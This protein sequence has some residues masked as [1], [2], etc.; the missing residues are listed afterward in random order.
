MRHIPLT[1]PR[2]ARRWRFARPNMKGPQD[3]H[4]SIAYLVLNNDPEAVSTGN[5]ERA[6]RPRRRIPTPVDLVNRRPQ[7]ME[8]A[9]ARGMTKFREGTGKLIL[10][11]RE[12]LVGP[13]PP[14]GR[15]GNHLGLRRSASGSTRRGR[16]RR[17][18]AT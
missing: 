1:E 13:A 15:R 18:A 16:S 5:G 7:L 2:W 6:L 8:W 3:R 14:R 10:P 9:I 4:H 12:D 11:G 17:S